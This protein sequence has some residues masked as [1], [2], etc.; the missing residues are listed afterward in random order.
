MHFLVVLAVIN[1]VIGVAD[2]QT[3]TSWSCENLIPDAGAQ[4]SSGEQIHS[5]LTG[6]SLTSFKA[7]GEQIRSGVNIIAV[8]D[9]SPAV[10]GGIQEGDVIIGANRVPI[11]HVSDLQKVACENS[12]LFLL[13]QRGEKQLM[14]YMRSE[15]SVGVGRT[16][17]VDRPTEFNQDEIDTSHA[18]ILE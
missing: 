1:T 11:R 5:S 2:A 8:E 18:V 3:D 4:A 7:L 14:F 10:R 17:S 16:D 9:D 12:R 6:A 13:I 15:D